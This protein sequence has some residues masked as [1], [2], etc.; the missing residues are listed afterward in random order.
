MR[1]YEFSLRR[2][3]LQKMYNAMTARS[4]SSREVGTVGGL[5]WVWV[6]PPAWFSVC[7]YTFIISHPFIF[8]GLEQPNL[9][10]TGAIVLLETERG[11]GSLTGKSEEKTSVAD[12]VVL[13]GQRHCR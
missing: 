5:V 11:V 6:V 7:H 4:L 13:G 1:L 8:R 3:V 12:F 2:R 10:L 9:H